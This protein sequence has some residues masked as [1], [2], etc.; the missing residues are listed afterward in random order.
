MLVTVQSYALPTK[1][2]GLG[3]PGPTFYTLGV[4]AARL[5][6]LDLC[7]ACALPVT[8]VSGPQQLQQAQARARSRYRRGEQQARLHGGA[9][10]QH[11]VLEQNAQRSL[12]VAVRPAS[13]GWGG[14]RGSGWVSAVQGGEIEARRCEERNRKLTC[15]RT[16]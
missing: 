14:K 2:F 15:S 12:V 3:V 7:A 10:G 8:L 9:G 13:R 1:P 4:E 11:K 5:G 16:D 6:D